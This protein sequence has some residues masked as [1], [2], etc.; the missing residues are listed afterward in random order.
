MKTFTKHTLIAGSSFAGGLIA[1][2]MINKAV[3]QSVVRSTREFKE[4]GTQ[5]FRDVKQAV[6]VPV[7]DFY[8]INDELKLEDEDLVDG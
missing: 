4:N 8:L 6:T 5:Y 2:I 1:G 7:P 3:F